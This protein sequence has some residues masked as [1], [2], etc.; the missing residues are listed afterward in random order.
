MLYE[1]V[2]PLIC[3]LLITV[4]FLFLIL[5]PELFLNGLF[6]F[7]CIFDCDTSTTPYMI[8]WYVIRTKFFGL[9]IHKFIRSD[10]ERALHDH[11]WSFI[12]IPIWR[13]Y[14]EHSE[15]NATRDEIN[16]LPAH[17]AIPEWPKAPVKRRVYP[18]IGTRFRRAEFRHRV[19]LLPCDDDRKYD[20]ESDCKTC[21]GVGCKPS[22]SIFI[23]FT[24][25]RLW[26]FNFPTGWI[27][28]NTWWQQHCSEESEPGQPN[29]TKPS[30][31]E[32]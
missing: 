32:I 6:K 30:S 10:F 20:W 22:W 5:G 8:R 19:E 29:N 17:F 3:G 31:I 26:G 13:G 16:S 12:V 28:A 23:R 11:P 9:F 25:R 24:N 1:I 15:R 2:L 27:E 7:K 4:V 21:G 14:I 18:I